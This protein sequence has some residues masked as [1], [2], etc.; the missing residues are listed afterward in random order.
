MTTPSYND[1]DCV[2]GHR[3]DCWDYRGPLQGDPGLLREALLQIF[4]LTADRPEI[5]EIARRALS[6]P[7][8]SEPAEVED[9]CDW[10]QRPQRDHLGDNGLECPTPERT[11]FW[12]ADRAA[13]KGSPDE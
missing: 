7:S 13:D 12:S 3:C 2:A 9:R 10:C 11:R 6:V 1:C 8:W 5:R 4:D